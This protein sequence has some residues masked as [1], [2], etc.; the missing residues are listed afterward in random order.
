M[1]SNHLTEAGLYPSCGLHTAMQGGGPM[2]G[3]PPLRP[4]DLGQLRDPWEVP[5]HLGVSRQEVR[6][7]RQQAP[8]H[9][10]VIV[11][12]YVEACRALDL[13][14]SPLFGEVCA[15]FDRAASLQ[16][17]AGVSVFAVVVGRLWQPWRGLEQHAFAWSSTSLA[18]TCYV[19][20]LS[21]MGAWGHASL[22]PTRV[23]G[24]A[25]RPQKH[26]LTMCSLSF[27]HRD[28]GRLGSISRRS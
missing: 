15:Q 3:W 6:S 5:Q 16:Q 7:R 14:P 4:L 20:S 12:C 19:L 17:D 9:I 8:R 27:V 2:C 25:P 13:G 22:K 1:F 26:L 28:P 24:S 10:P 11:F 18:C 23:F 21:Y